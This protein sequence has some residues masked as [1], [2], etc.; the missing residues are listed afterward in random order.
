MITAF[1]RYLDT[2]VVRGFFIIMVLA[3][4]TWGIGDVVR[5]FGTQSWV[6]KVGGQSIEVPQ[7]QD[8]YQRQMAQ[9]TRSLPS[10]TEPTAE[11]RQTAAKQALEQLISQLAVTQEEQRLRISVPDGALRQAVFAIPAFH[12][13]NGQFDRQTFETVLRNNGLTEQRFLDLMRG[14]LAQRQLFSS[15]AAG[16]A[17]SDLLANQMFDYQNEKRS[18][19]MVEFPFAAAPTPATP[20]EAELQRWYDNHPDLYSTPEYRK[21][22]AAVLSPQTLAKDIEIS[23]ADLQTAYDQRKADYVTVG[24]RSVQV[25]QAPDQAK[26]QALA[27]QWRGGADWDA[28]QKAAKDAGASAVELDNAA[29]SEFPSPE[30]GKA[31]FAATPNEVSEPVQGPLGWSVV[32]VIKDTPGQSRSFDQVKDELRARVLSDKAADLIYDRANKVDNVLASGAGLDELP[33]DLG[34]A[35]LAGTLDETGN[36]MDGSPAPIPGPAELKAAIIGAAF[37]AHKGDPP[38]LVEVQTPSTGGSAYYALTL[39]DVIPP[40]PK[41]FDAVKSQVETDWTADAQRHAEE[42]AAA[43]L[44]T[45][46]K[47]GQSL[48]DAATVAGVT[49]RRTPQVTRDSQQ[50]G[51][52]AQL[53]RVLFGLKPGEPAMVETPEEFIVAV[54]AETTTPDPKTDPLGYGKVRDAL[55][56]SI[57]SDIGDLFTDA[58]RQR[59]KPEISQQMLDS[60]SGQQ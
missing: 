27:T 59:A 55:T 56:Q 31:V 48:A 13:A 58:L 41:P 21:I 28:M 16:A 51:M 10:G 52:P 29:E 57:A 24:K 53:Q 44:L 37:Q 43:K 19:D 23:D 42:T 32:K 17:P 47:G 45:A 35:G 60:V 5:Q 38:R 14:D 11:M 9:L 40:A 49:V 1:R 46:V 18:A 30:L 7:V 33:G 36:T 20:T 25:I 3:F 12:G 8:A 6:A 50:D 54:P 4:M 22:K 39:Q 26:A 15:V 34:L 2:W